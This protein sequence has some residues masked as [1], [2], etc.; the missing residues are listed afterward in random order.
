M[1]PAFETA[2]GALLEANFQLKQG[3]LSGVA[4][5]DAR[6]PALASALVEMAKDH[7][8]TLQTPLYVDSNGEFHVNAMHPDGGMLTHGC[9]K[10]GLDF[11]AR[12]SKHSARTGMAPGH[13][14]ADNGWCRLNHFEA[15]KMVTEYL[16]EQRPVQPT[17]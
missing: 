4:H 3:G 11:A 2:M 8:V 7:E 1:N 5:R 6:E 15:E 12:L 17:N 10:F 14:S 16:R 9:G 13:I